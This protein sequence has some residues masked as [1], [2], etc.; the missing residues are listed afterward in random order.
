[1]TLCLLGRIRAQL[2]EPERDELDYMLATPE[3]YSTRVIS[4]TLTVAGN[5]VRKDCVHQHRREW[6]ACF[7]DR[8][9][10]NVPA[11]HR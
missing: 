9:E 5:P 6:C 1:M 8:G 7:I 2:D 10:P 11:G 4:Q 3:K